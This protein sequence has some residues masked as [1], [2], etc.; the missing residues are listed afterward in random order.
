MAGFLFTA[1]PRWL[2][3]PPVAAGSLFAPVGAQLAGWLIF[4][5]ALL[6]GGERSP[7]LAGMGLAAVAA[8][9]S[10]LAWRFRRL[11]VHSRVAERTHAR[12]LRAACMAG[13]LLLDVTV[14]AVMAQAWVLVQ[15]LAQ[16]AL[17][18]CIGVAYAAA[19]HRMMPFF[20]AVS[21]RLESR[22]PQWLLWSL[23]G[24]MALQ[25]LLEPLL[26]LGALPEPGL[27]GA[28]RLVQGALGAAV[29]SL[30]WRWSR[31]QNLR[32]RLLAMLQRG[33]VWLG[34]ALLLSALG[35][36][37]AALHAYALG[38]LGTTLLAMAT[39]VA[40]GNT[41]RAVVADDFLWLLHRLLQT[42]VLLRL[43]AALWPATA[44]WNGP[45]AAL[46]WTAVALG[47]L[48]RNGRWLGQPAR[49]RTPR[50]GGAREPAG[51]AAES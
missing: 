21:E 27:R 31:V 35:Q 41:G 30:A 3:C 12:V 20:G 16:C 25:A 34:V 15:A 13:A 42:A 46:V 8:G 47:W 22:W 40:C 24:V 5:L 23:V 6:D 39:R 18:G 32:Q 9:W 1:V 11:L 48:L 29:L 26:L 43:A 17:W 38:F 51:A 45:L 36:P 2:G 49:V 44:Y 14:A 50:S 10:S 28:L 33:L 7:L 19:L 4:G 37:A